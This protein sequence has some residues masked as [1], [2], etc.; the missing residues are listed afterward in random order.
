M[1]LSIFI[2][3]EREEEVI[4]YAHE[5]NDIVMSIERLVRENSVELLGYKDDSVEKLFAQRTYV[6]WL[7]T[8]SCRHSICY[9]VAHISGF[10]AFR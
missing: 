9:T 10:F 1:K 7:R 4:V 8:D 2:D 5:K 3:K 6:R